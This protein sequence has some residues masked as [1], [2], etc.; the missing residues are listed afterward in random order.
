MDGKPHLT[1]APFT[2]R[3]EECPSLYLNG[4][5]LPKTDTV[6]YLGLHLDKRLKREHL[7]IK[8]KSLYWLLGAKS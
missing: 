3:R 7:N 1:Y 2:L 4:S 8:T 6:K 5:A